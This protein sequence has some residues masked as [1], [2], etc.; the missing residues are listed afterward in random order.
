MKPTPALFTDTW[1][2][3][4]LDAAAL[5]GTGGAA[6]AVHSPIDGALLAHAPAPFN[7][8]TCQSRRRER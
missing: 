3:L 7:H 8:P 6:I 2:E 5:S 4:G 1:A